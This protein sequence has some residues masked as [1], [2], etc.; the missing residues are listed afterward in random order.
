[1]LDQTPIWSAPSDQPKLGPRDVHIWRTS[2][3]PP[4]E[5]AGRFRTLLAA[6]ELTKADR[7]R[8]E[9]DRR[10]Y[11]V[12]RGILRELLSRYLGVPSTD[13]RFSYSEYGKPELIFPET[14]QLKFNLAHSGEVALYAFTLMGDVGIDVEFI[15]PEFTADDIARRYFSTSEVNSLN[16]LPDDVRHQAFFNCWTRKEAVIKAKGMG[17]SLGL[18]QF[19]VTLAPGEPALLLRTRWDEAEV[20]RWS[21]RAINVGEQYAAAIAIDAHDFHAS[22]FEYATGS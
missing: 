16:R 6:D 22:Y 1:M 9:K 11:S 3:E 20:T 12:A 13:L 8:F 4:P 15:R 17:L 18:D 5:A 7:F 10:H 2:L 19:D 21:L 14:P